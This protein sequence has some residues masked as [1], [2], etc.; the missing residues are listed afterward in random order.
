MAADAL[1]DPWSLFVRLSNVG[2]KD[3][4]HPLTLE[5][6]CLVATT[7]SIIKKGP[8]VTGLIAQDVEKVL[9]EAVHQGELL[10]INYGQMMGLI[11]EAIKELRQEINA[12]KK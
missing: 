8:I 1:R 3:G 12:L 4:F 2:I 6:A 5:V 9:P 7:N 11:V 10:A